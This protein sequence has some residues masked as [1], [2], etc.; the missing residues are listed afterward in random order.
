[1]SSYSSTTDNEIAEV[2]KDSTLSPAILFLNYTLF[3]PPFVLSET[4]LRWTECNN[5]NTE[6]TSPSLLTT[7]TLQRF[8]CSFA[9]TL[10]TY[11][12]PIFSSL[13]QHICLALSTNDCNAKWQLFK[14]TRGTKHVQI[15]SIMI[16][17]RG[18]LGLMLY[19]RTTPTF[20]TPSLMT[21]DP[22]AN[23]ALNS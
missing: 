15:W 22:A 16:T 5:F 18:N 2:A 7:W 6:V 23:V 1:M 13:C 11:M 21:L 20:R 17:A 4:T 12:F 8:S 9:K 3:C 10:R 14:A 19:A